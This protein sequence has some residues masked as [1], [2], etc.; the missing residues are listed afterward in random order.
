MTSEVVYAIIDKESGLYV[1]RGLFPNLE[2]LG[3]NTRLFRSKVDAM[4]YV[5]A[6][7]PHDKITILQN[8]LAWRLLEGI[9]GV[10]RW[11]IN[12][13]LDEYMDAA[14]QFK[15]LKVLPVNLEC[16]DNVE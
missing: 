7:H 3:E 16:R 13:T 12:C 2:I 15:N 5:E 1:T 6:R 11:H 10:D 4:Q 14:R 8:N 9:H